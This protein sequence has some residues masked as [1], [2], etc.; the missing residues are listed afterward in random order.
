[1]FISLC[2]LFNWKMILNTLILNI[3]ILNTRKAAKSQKVH[4]K[5]LKK[6]MDFV[7]AGMKPFKRVPQA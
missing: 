4:G 7:V 2:D 3:L 6:E 1:M 5:N